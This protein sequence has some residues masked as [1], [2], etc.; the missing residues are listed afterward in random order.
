MTDTFF[1]EM[2]RLPPVA[3]ETRLITAFQKSW[4]YVPPP[5]PIVLCEVWLKCPFLDLYT[6]VLGG[7]GYYC[8]DINARK[9]VLT[10]ST[11]WGEFF[12]EA[13]GDILLP[14]F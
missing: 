13:P 5:P 12:N 8:W 7:G 11:L 4:E 1:F 10:D 9:E 2:R 3:F 14:E 6:A